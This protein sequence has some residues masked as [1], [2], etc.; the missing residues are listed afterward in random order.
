MLVGGAFDEFD[1]LASA[2]NYDEETNTT[3]I[4]LGVGSITLQT[5]PT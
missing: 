3:T 1:D 4:D 5:S 2:I